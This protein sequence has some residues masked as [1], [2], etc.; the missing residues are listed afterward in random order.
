MLFSSARASI[1]DLAHLQRDSTAVF[2]H[3]FPPPPAGETR[4]N[5]GDVGLRF[6]FLSSSLYQHC[7]VD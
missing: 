7:E 3:F 1:Q 6:R 5:E 4:E 2:L